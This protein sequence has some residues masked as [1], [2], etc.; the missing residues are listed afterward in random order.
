[1]FGRQVGRAINAGFPVY[2]GCPGSVTTDLRTAGRSTEVHWGAPQLPREIGK[3]LIWLCDIPPFRA[4][5]PQPPQ[6][7]YAIC[8][9]LLL[10]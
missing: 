6:I 2:S 3:S 8:N 5:R 9:D 4:L 1:M 10:E 7:V